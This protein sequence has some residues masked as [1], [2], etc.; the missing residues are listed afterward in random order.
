MKEASAMT[1]RPLPPRRARPA[2]CVLSVML[3][4]L[5]GALYLQHNSWLIS[6]GP[7]EAAAA[8][9]AAASAAAAVVAREAMEAATYSRR[10]L[11]E[12][13]YEPSAE[14]LALVSNASAKDC[15]QTTGDF[16]RNRILIVHEQHLQSMGCV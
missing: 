9:A 5:Q 12:E 3:V 2:I 14:A 10:N 15:G 13:A 11:T 6:S 4:L 16:P 1:D 7:R 8:A